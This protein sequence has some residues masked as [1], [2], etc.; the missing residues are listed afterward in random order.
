MTI[1]EVQKV[2]CWTFLKLCV[3]LESVWATFLVSKGLLSLLWDP[4]KPL[5]MSI[6]LRLGSLFEHDYWEYP[7]L[8]L[9]RLALLKIVQRKNW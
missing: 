4:A 6:R 2:V 9:H 5:K 3:S 8:K 1:L 7:E